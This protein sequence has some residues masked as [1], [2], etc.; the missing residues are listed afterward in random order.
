MHS[1]DTAQLENNAH[2]SLIQELVFHLWH[3]VCALRRILVRI[4]RALNTS[5]F[6]ETLHASKFDSTIT[7]K[8]VQEI[9]NLNS[10]ITRELLLRSKNIVSQLSQESKLPWVD[11]AV[12]YESTLIL[13]SRG[14]IA[15]AINYADFGRRYLA[16]RIQ[17][18][19][20]APTTEVN[21]SGMVA[22]NPLLFSSESEPEKGFEDAAKHLFSL[23]LGVTL[24]S[25]KAAKQGL[26]RFR[27][28]TEYDF[29]GPWDMLLD[30]IRS[31]AGAFKLS[32]ILHI[33]ST[34]RVLLQ[35]YMTNFHDDERVPLDAKSDRRVLTKSMIEAYE[36]LE[37]IVS[38]SDQHDEWF[39]GMMLAKIQQ[40]AGMLFSNITPVSLLDRD[41]EKE[42]TH[43]EYKELAEKVY[44]YIQKGWEREYDRPVV[45]RTKLRR[46]IVTDMIRRS[47]TMTG[48]P[49]LTEMKETIGDPTV[50]NPHSS[51][52][53]S[54]FLWGSST[55]PS[56]S[57]H[58]KLFPQGNV[59][60]A[61]VSTLLGY[62]QCLEVM[63]E[64]QNKYG[65]YDD[66]TATFKFTGTRQWGLTKE[67]PKPQFTIGHVGGFKK[68]IDN[69]L[70][71]ATN[72]DKLPNFRKYLTRVNRMDSMMFLG[73]SLNL[74][75]D[76][77]VQ[78]LGE[79]AEGALDEAARASKTLTFEQPNG[80][81]IH[82]HDVIYA[83]QEASQSPMWL[84]ALQ[85][86]KS[87]KEQ[88][89]ILILDQIFR[90]I[91]SRLYFLSVRTEQLARVVSE[92][93]LR[94][95]YLS[96][97][98]LILDQNRVL[99]KFLITNWKTN[100]ELFDIGNSENIG[101]VF[102]NE[103]FES[104]QNY[105][106]KNKGH[107][108]H[109]FKIEQYIDR[110]SEIT[111]PLNDVA[112]AYFVSNSIESL[113]VMAD[114]LDE[115]HKNLEFNESIGVDWETLLVEA[116]YRKYEGSKQ[117]GDNSAATGVMTLGSEDTEGS[118]SEKA[119]PN[120]R[121]AK[122]AL[123]HLD[124]HTGREWILWARLAFYPLALDGRILRSGTTFSELNKP[125]ENSINKIESSTEATS[126]IWKTT[127]IAYRKPFTGIPKNN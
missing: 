92:Q 11:V 38:S 120:E 119:G 84:P 101:H 28:M 68:D 127:L 43:N 113:K 39:R 54:E 102:N 115:I 52:G 108:G 100:A 70:K 25:S 81:Y 10:T 63:N 31:A 80:Q 3:D 75:E 123:Q 91:F 76:L 106:G 26:Q 32:S 8:T 78:E 88:D 13:R 59:N 24:N 1:F 40:D 90:N 124:E 82:V 29:W 15:R 55:R 62:I 42:D 60:K 104:L 77:L 45:V 37:N 46:A 53:F 118:N 112:L 44:A 5:L 95:P 122:E 47:L 27:Q 117:L 110:S 7:G 51:K 17:E 67:N 18:D 87:N 34:L 72:K 61:Q 74:I 35:N 85:D 69:Q 125:F 65:P 71:K 12:I 49:L 4:E 66:L 21:V 58:L 97:C 36:S 109:Q 86:L 19:T 22:F 57:R 121:T 105:F 48:R 114:D 98:A 64:E 93:P 16:E 50:P 116:V 89:K 41:W 56:S 20:I 14:D 2:Q 6:S 73:S 9:S 30:K 126:L 83:A 33:E 99:L 111:P 107:L 94:Q 23:S 96:S 103:L 79:D